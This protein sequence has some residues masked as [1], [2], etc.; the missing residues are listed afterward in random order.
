MSAPA[1]LL[2]E[3]RCPACGQASRV[4][5]EFA[6]RA[7]KCPGCLE[8]VQ[9][10]RPPGPE[11]ASDGAASDG[12]ASD[13]AASD[14]AASD[15]AAS[16]GAASCRWVEIPAA[17][18]SASALPDK[19]CVSCGEAIRALAR[20]C[21][22]CGDYQSERERQV[23][24]GLD[25]GSLLPVAPLDRRIA[26]F[27]LNALCGV[28]PLALLFGGT[29]LVAEWY[30]SSTQAHVLAWLVLLLGGLAFLALQ[31]AMIARS[32]A[33]LG[34]RA[35]GIKLVRT[36]GS[37][38]GLVDGVILREW[39]WWGPLVVLFFT[40]LGPLLVLASSL[41]TLGPNRRSLH[42]LLAGT[43]VVKADQA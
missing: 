18:P 5:P 28:T 21:P 22:F 19:P 15:G 42:D 24:R 37:A 40:G 16:D 43:V 33:N 8:L 41:A 7:G 31:W 23:L 35:L 20:R 14:G 26:A 13:G 39:T 4:L 38:V 3:V 34:M 17:A 27:L 11:A 10:E 2:I 30:V 32:G 29:S 1:G 12:A 6:G 25:G 9:V 36:D